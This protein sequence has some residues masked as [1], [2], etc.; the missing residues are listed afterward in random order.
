MEY[1]R[2]IE[3]I[4]A[5]RVKVG[6]AQAAALR[7][8]YRCDVRLSELSEELGEAAGGDAE[9]VG[10]TAGEITEELGKVSRARNNAARKLIRCRDRLLE[11]DEEERRCAG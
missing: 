11:L 8:S 4:R 2:S 7:K 6:K 1:T 9:A 5:E 3:E 10:R